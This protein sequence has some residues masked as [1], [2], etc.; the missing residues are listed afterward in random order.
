MRRYALKSSIFYLA[1]LTI[2]FIFAEISFLLQQSQSYLGAFKLVA[3][4]LHIPL[5]VVP[6]ILYYL[7]MQCL[8]HVVWLLCVLS[9]TVGFAQTLRLTQRS[10]E[11]CAIGFW[12]LSLFFILL[13]NQLYFPNS[14]FS[15][16]LAT[17]KHYALF[18]ALF[19]L[20]A[21]LIAIIIAIAGLYGLRVLW[22]YRV[23]SLVSLVIFLLC[24][25]IVII[26]RQHHI[27][28]DAGTPERP[29]IILIGVDSLRPDYLGFNGASLRT[30][31]IDQ[32]LDHSTVFSNAMTPLARTWP[33]WM[34]ILTGEFPQTS[35]ART[36]LLDP[37]ALKAH[38]TLPSLLKNHG[39]STIYATDESRF[40]NIDQSF[41][42]DEIATPPM[43]FNDFL[44]GTINDFP[45]SNM[46]INTWIGQYL[47]PWSYANRA[48]EHVYD[49]DTFLKRMRVVL[50]K[51]RQAPLFLA[52]HF[53]LPH[54]PY[55]WKSLPTHNRPTVAHYR[56]SIERVDQQ[57]AAFM[58][59]LKENKLLEHSIVVLLSDH[60][61][62]LELPGDRITEPNLFVK[63]KK[64]KVAPHFYPPSAD[65]E[66]LNM[67]GG[68]GTDVLGL[69]Q[70]H[71]VLAMH[72]FGVPGLQRG[73]V[74]PGLASLIDIKPTLLDYLKL[75]SFQTD[76]YSLLPQLLGKSH[77][78][79]SHKNFWI[80]SDFTPASV[81][82]AHPEVS[83][84]LFEGIN[85]FRIDPVTTRIRIRDTML[86]LVLSSKQYADYR[87]QWV[88][89]LYPQSHQKMIP[90]LVNLE[91]GRWTTDLNSSFAKSSP[92]NEMML[93][94]KKYIYTS[95][96]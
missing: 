51:P 53:C 90:V 2:F 72:G 96:T 50:S 29:N 10:M 47:F 74:I 95:H 42:F 28:T 13:I 36:N 89:A 59:L 45:L 20:N 41:G 18:H 1:F 62:G 57:F 31:H 65:R 79:T 67:S 78:V 87:D 73:Q 66:T 64:Q 14:N 40:S 71:T 39:Y 93:S 23:R 94:L 75:T 33:S 27:P 46:L 69:P 12:F 16:Y 80:E 6:A 54:Y 58:M 4:H 30:P 85:Y 15:G 38:S 52:I 9:V 60:G 92:A 17:D 44:L 48:A 22:R 43:G 32:F 84:V 56:A 37:S 25:T 26:Q 83:K 81:R 35:G 8:L 91:S 49:P 70:Y 3:N 24:Y 61:E 86:K 77:R 82:S 88:L 21:S 19:I 76:G 7:T 11:Y 5:N 55:G 68:H 63:T 34:S